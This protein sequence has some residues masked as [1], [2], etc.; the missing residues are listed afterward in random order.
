LVSRRQS[1]GRPGPEH[2]DP[3]AFVTGL[4]PPEY[5]GRFRRTTWE[6]LTATTVRGVPDLEP[7]VEYLASKTAFGRT[8]LDV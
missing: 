8:A 3:T 1:E 2:A 7:L 4:L 6:D 5:R